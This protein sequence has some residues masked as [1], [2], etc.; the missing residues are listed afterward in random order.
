MPTVA[1]SW[2]ST[3]VTETMT[4]ETGRTSQTAV[5]SPQHPRFTESGSSSTPKLNRKGFSLNKR[6]HLEDLNLLVR[7]EG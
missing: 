4:V 2:T 6:P 7:M 3:T 1:A 5:S